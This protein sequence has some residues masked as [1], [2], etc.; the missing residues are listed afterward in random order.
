[1]QGARYKELIAYQK[2]FGV[3]K[4]DLHANRQVSKRRDLR[5]C[6]SIKKSGG[7]HSD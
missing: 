4:E 2:S 6:F 1:M 7:I 3:G 5:R